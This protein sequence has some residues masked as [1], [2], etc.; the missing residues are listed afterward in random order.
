MKKYIIILITLAVIGTTSCEEWLDVN[1]NPNDATSATPD[2]VLPGVL[3]TWGSQ[4]ND[5]TTTVGAWMGYWA[6][7]GGWSGWYTTKKYEI[8][9][10]FY[11]GPFDGYYAGVLTDTK[12]IRDNSGTNFIYP[13]ITN[14]VDAWYYSRLVDLYGDVP[15]SEACDPSLTLTPVYDDDATIYASLIVRLDTAIAVFN[16]KISTGYGST[17]ADYSFKN[18]VDV[19]YGGDFSKWLK[20]ANTMKLRLVMRMTNVKSNSELQ[21]LMSN[22]A[23]L[24]F[25]TADAILNPGYTASSGKTNPLW[26]TFGKSYDGTVQSANTQYCLNAYFHEKMSSYGDPRLRQYFQPG[27]SA[28]P[29]GALI[30]IKLGTDG[31][32]T[33]QPNTT[34]AAGYSWIPIAADGSAA[35]TT[36]TGN[37]ALDGQK[38]FLYTEACFL[39]A[40]AVVRGVITGDAGTL[41][42]DGI[43]ASMDAAKVVNEE[44]DYLVDT[45]LASSAVLW[46][47][48][49]S[50]A[51]KVKRIIVQKYISNYFVN[52]FESYCDYRRTGYPSPKRPDDITLDPDNEMLSYYPSGIIRRQIPRLF[53]YPIQEFTLNK[54]NVQAAVDLQGVSFTTDSYPFDARVFWDTAPTTITY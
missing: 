11:P 50:T 49:L 39:Q 35:G 52:M 21:A 25:I 28:D 31:D 54:E 34:V 33:V 40:E 19:L 1:Y 14:V 51:D 38:V 6:H 12:F 41:Y 46:D 32:L 53:P 23:S 10:T 36:K 3:K 42:E 29:A 17:S 18:T 22:T 26:N 30:S 8:T 45:Y 27:V 2:L 13:A 20:L 43:I 15:Y 48:A 16:R 9:S 4:V 7:A 47:D 44:P 5:F 37:G 24:G